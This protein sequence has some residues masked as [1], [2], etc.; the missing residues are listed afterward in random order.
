MSATPL[1]APRTVVNFA[2]ERKGDRCSAIAI[3][4]SES[5]RSAVA[6]R[7]RIDALT[8]GGRA[9]VGTILTAPPNGS[10]L[11]ARVVALAAFPGAIGWDLFV[12]PVAP[13]PANV[14]GYLK[15]E[16]VEDPGQFGLQT[17]DGSQILNGTDGPYRHDAA[18][19]A[20][21]TAIPVASRVRGWSCIAGAALATVSIQSPI[22][23]VLPLI[24]VPAG[25]TFG[26]TP[27][28]LQGPVTFT[29]AGDVAS[30]WVSWLEQV[31]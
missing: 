15:V 3:G 2:A 16:T 30:R 11:G 17:F 26:D 6:W 18:A 24:T 29:F 4:L 22:F 8:N 13:Y 19:A 25:A 1:R 5:S 14:G 9:R 27:D 23:G 28:N 10:R 7:I 21:A 12:Q 20:G 31:G